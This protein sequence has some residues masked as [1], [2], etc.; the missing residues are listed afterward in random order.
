MRGGG[1]WK[2]AT[3]VRVGNVHIHQVIKGTG[4]EQLLPSMLLISSCIKIWC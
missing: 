4:V 3:I 1:V 2:L